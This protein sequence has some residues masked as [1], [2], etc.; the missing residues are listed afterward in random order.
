MSQNGTLQAAL[1]EAKTQSGISLD[2]LSRRSPVLVV[3][4]RHAGCPF[5]REAISELA[6]QQ[7]SIAIAG[8][9]LVFVHML[10]ESAAAPLFELRGMGDVLRISDPTQK[11]YQAFELRRGSVWQVAGPGTWWRGLKTV[12]SGNG[13]GVPA[14]DILQLPGAFLLQDGRIVKAFRHKTSSDR[15]NYQEL[16]RCPLSQG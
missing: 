3:F 8:T 1:L 10:E 11:L 7:K 5:T 4:L 2:E 14:G 12:L 15:P 16:A 6:A 9:V 13:F